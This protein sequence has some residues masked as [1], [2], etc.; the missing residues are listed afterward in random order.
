M[1]WHR[2]SIQEAFEL[3]GT[4][5]DG[6]STSAAEIKLMQ[7]GPNELDEGK[8]KSIAGMLLAQ[9][10]DV[11]IL[12][13]MAAAIISG[14]IGD[15]TD[16]IVILIIV[17]LNAFIGF[18]QEYR[19]EKAM[20][21]LK[22]MA[23]TQAR[24]L[25]DGIVIWL[26]ATELVPGDVVLLEAGNSV[27]A[28]LRIIE[29]INLKIE[30]AALTGESHAIEKN[31]QALDTDDIS[32]GD[33]KNMAFKGTFVTYGR[34]K[35]VVIATGM[36]TELGRI[37]K[38]LQ[39]EESLTPLQQRMA[40]FGKKLSIL[41]L[42]LCIVFFVAGWLRGEDIIKM[43]LT[44][45]SLAVAAIP[46][47][48][49]AVI[50][51]SLA[52]AAKRMIRFNSLIRKLPAVETLGSV[53]YIC[54]DKTGT[55]TKNKMHVEQVFVNGQ[56]YERDELIAHRQ[57]EAVSL[58]L[59]AFALNNDAFEDKDKNIKGDST[60]IALLEVA[61]EHNV[62]P[63]VWPRLAEIAFDS[64]RKLMTTFHRYN[65]SIISLTKGAPDI[66][67]Q[68]CDDIDSGA[69][70]NQV[71]EMADKG[72]RVLGFAYR[73]WDDLPENPSS[74]FHESGLRFIGLTGIIDPPREEVF[75]AVSQ[76]K[77]AGIVP[78]MITGDHPITAKTIAQRIGILSSEND[79]VITGQQLAAMDNESFLSKV[80]MIK[81][82]ARVSP[83]QKLQIVKALQENGHYIAMTGDGVNDAPSLKRAN[84]GIAMGITGT[85]V[86]KEAAHMILLDDNFS[87][88]VKAVREGRRIYDNIL[89]FIKYLMT[90]NSGELWTLLLGPMLGLPVALLPIHILWINLVT[91]GLPAISL[92][93]EK[94]EKDIMK[95]PPRPPQQSVFANGRGLHMIWVGLLMAVI[96]LAAQG[97][98]INRGLH[99][100]TIVFNILCLSQI[101]HV[102]A[103]RSMR[104]SF[105]SSGMFSNKALIAAVV[106]AVGLQF[107]VTYIPFLQ[108]IFQTEALTLKE[109]TIV[110]ILSS[111]VFFAVEIEKAISRRGNRNY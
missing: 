63:D 41:V 100:Q 8:K 46:E 4:N 11:M 13:L 81:V 101:G 103:I 66:L 111:L 51:I 94:A 99:W 58:L 64:D 45:I 49:P 27:P 26:P 70:Q 35:G 17:L 105:F 69:M 59:H 1:N 43:V 98:A 20:Q 14:I 25:R 60:E 40:S 90:T 82:Y 78:V 74:E 71:E 83:D 7:T 10:K 95:R 29:S 88:I 56:L 110:F 12:V 93:F 55:L 16:T 19:A 107:V 53:T 3:L 23:V 34:G 68:R 33:K 80:D 57:K 22:Q 2:L 28:D 89:K 77:T 54:T 21:A 37:A 32:V 31:T 47:A 36:Q 5:Q 9:F 79:I 97:W 73:I 96:T 39:E 108:P 48:L 104:Q 67:L 72:H 30:E 24:V 15:V 92:S 84:I 18:I 106:L 102:L 61:L 62:L 109:V 38:M 86:S 52:L 85:D 50:T 76:C 91:D 75:D 42:F 6:L 44:S 87:T 65:S